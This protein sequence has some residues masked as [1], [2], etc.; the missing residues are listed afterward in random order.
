MRLIL[1]SAQSISM[2]LMY[3]VSAGLDENTQMGLALVQ[4][5]G[6]LTETASE[7]VM[8]EDVLQNLLYKKI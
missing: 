6:A 1:S 3:S 4:V 5:L 2:S 7:T 8:N